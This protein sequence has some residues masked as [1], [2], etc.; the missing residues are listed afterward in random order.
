M[1]W[2]PAYNCPSVCSENERKMITPAKNI[3]CFMPSTNNTPLDISLAKMLLIYAACQFK[4][5]EV[6]L[7]LVFPPHM[8]QNKELLLLKQWH[9]KVVYTDRTVSIKLSNSICC[10]HIDL[11]LRREKRNECYLS[12]TTLR[13][14]G[15]KLFKNVIVRGRGM[16]GK[17]PNATNGKNKKV[18]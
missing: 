13:P 2:F 17:D 8:L 7:L 12:C 3:Y 4:N 16:R 1:L 6:P 15:L 11:K 10:D 9:C 5:G 18:N 14:F